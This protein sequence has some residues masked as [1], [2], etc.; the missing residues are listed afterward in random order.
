MSWWA[1][2]FSLAI[3]IVRLCGRYI[4]IERFFPEDKVMM[5]S[6]IPLTIRM[7]LIHFVLIWGTNNTQLGQVTTDEISRKE[8]GSKLV[9]AARIFY[10]IFIWTAKLTVCEFL[11]RVTGIVTR[12]SLLHIPT[13]HP[14]LPYINPGRRYYPG[15]SCR[16]GY[17]NL[18]TMGTCDVITDL[19]LVA[20]PVP[21][22]LMAQIPLKRKLALTILFCLSLILVAITCYRVPSV[23]EHSGSQQYRSLIASFEILAATAVSNMVVIGSFVRDSGVKKLKY[24]RDQG[25][26]SV[27]ESMDNSTVRRNTV[28]QS[29]WG[30]DSDLA[31][32]MGIKLDPKLYSST[33]AG[34][35]PVSAPPVPLLVARTGSIDPAWSF[36]QGRSSDDQASSPDSLDIKVSPREYIQT[37]QSPRERAATASSNLSS[38]RVSFFDVGGLLNQDEPQVQP[39]HRSFTLIPSHPSQNNLEPRRNRRGSRAFLED[40]G[41]LPRP[42]LSTTQRAY[43]S[44]ASLDTLSHSLPPYRASPVVSLDV[45]VELQDVGGL[46]SRNRAPL[47]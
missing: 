17:A 37:N 18:I 43:T 11:K 19:L 44:P 33:P 39:I 36:D 6:V 16:S 9:L 32:G 5:I 42:T 7:V 14:T 1:T 45:D 2:A 27:S 24:K 47:S 8:M 41:V 13:L 25:S 30:S 26:A 31:T 23:I 28:M 15:P 10:A 20:F 3:I 29:H 35:V 21:I 34:N 46:L 22:I 12:R 4:R 38:P 40:L